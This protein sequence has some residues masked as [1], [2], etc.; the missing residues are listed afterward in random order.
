M[1]SCTVADFL[2]RIIKTWQRLAALPASYSGTGTE[3]E[4]ALETSGAQCFPGDARQLRGARCRRLHLTSAGQPF[5]KQRQKSNGKRNF[6][7]G[8]HE[9]FTTFAEGNDRLG[10]II[11]RQY[12]L[13]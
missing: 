8:L 9:F 5:L 1:F 7:T 12:L 4:C 6:E 3:W 2:A 10:Q 13:H 11:N